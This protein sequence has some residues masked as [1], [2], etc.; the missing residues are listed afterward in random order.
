MNI[1]IYGAPQLEVKYIQ[2]PQGHTPTWENILP[3]AAKSRWMK[4]RLTAINKREFTLHQKAYGTAG[5]SIP[6]LTKQIKK[7]AKSYGGAVYERKGFPGIIGKWRIPMDALDDFVS[8]MRSD[9]PQYELEFDGL[10]DKYGDNNKDKQVGSS[11]HVPTIRTVQQR[12]RKSR[13]FGDLKIEPQ[14]QFNNLRLYTVIYTGPKYGLILVSCNGRCVVKSHE[15]ASRN[16]YPKIGS[17]IASCNG[18][19]IP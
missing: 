6:F 14:Y 10:K 12:Y 15:S 1:S 11:E 7:L 13:L 2:L 5:C 16:Q 17:I 19:M 4:L 18:Y 3:R 8:Y 9:Y